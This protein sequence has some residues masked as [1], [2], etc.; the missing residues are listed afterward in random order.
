MVR[1][2]EIDLAQVNESEAF[3]YD[4]QE[5]TV[6]PDYRLPERYNDI[7][8]ITLKQRVSFPTT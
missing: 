7:A 6:H 3:D 2:G 5:I 1:L 8:I 4:V